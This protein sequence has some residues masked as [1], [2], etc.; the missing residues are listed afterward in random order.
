MTSQC[1]RRRSILTRQRAHFIIIGAKKCATTSL[2]RWL[3]EH[4]SVHTSSGKEPSFFSRHQQWERG[5][6]WY[7]SLFA[8]AD[9][10][11][12]TGEGG[13]YASSRLSPE[14]IPRIRDVVPDVRLLY[15]V[16]HPVDRLRS[17]YRHDVQR[18]RETRSLADAVTAAGSRYVANSCYDRLVAPWLDAFGDQLLILRFEDLVG[19]EDAAWRRILDHL[20]LD[21]VPRPGTNANPTG[22]TPR[23]SALFRWLWERGLDRPLYRLPEPIRRL[24]RRLLLRDDDR[25]RELLEESRT[26]RVPQTVRDRIWRDVR[27][28]E[29]RLGRGRLWER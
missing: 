22:A 3:G 13:N 4:P 8:G 2:F 18:G 12:V 23:F 24:G 11:Q 17:D 27:R 6:G 20:G 16:R 19:P 9:P 15:V 28:L 7:D 21:P 25:Y 14:T 29:R 1:R 5:V 26:A 10:D